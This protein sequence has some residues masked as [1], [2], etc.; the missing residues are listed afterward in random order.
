VIK[1]AQMFRNFKVLMALMLVFVLI[2]SSYAFAAANTIEVSNAGQGSDTVSGYGITNLV[3][4]LN[5][6]DPTT[7]DTITFT[8]TPDPA[9]TNKI[10]AK[11]VYLQ[12]DQ[13]ATW[14][15][16]T[17]SV[18]VDPVVNASC[19]YTKATSLLMKDVDITNVVASSTT[20]TG[21]AIP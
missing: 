10:A 8:V 5:D 11:V 1:E 15:Q 12:A 13:S 4:N 16:C 7:V 19:D 14:I 2:G 17:V 3:Y 6:T 20:G 21:P 18:A 9:G